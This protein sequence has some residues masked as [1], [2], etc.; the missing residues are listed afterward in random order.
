M[1]VRKYQSLLEQ[2]KTVILLSLKE[3]GKFPELDELIKHIP[4]KY[5]KILEHYFEIMIKKEKIK[6]I[7]P[8]TIATNFAFIN[9]GY[10][11]M[12]TRIN[13]GEETFSVDDFI[14]NNIKFFIQSLQ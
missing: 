11:F 1:L 14:E 2:K 3:E 8:F 13:L 5:I 4:L 12:K 9:F 6:K 10:F 7:D